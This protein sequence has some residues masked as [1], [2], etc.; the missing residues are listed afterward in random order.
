MFVPCTDE[1]VFGCQLEHVCPSEPP[2]VPVFVQQCIRCIER[3]E[4]NMKTDGLYRA[5]GN[6]SQVQKIRLQVTVKTIIYI[7]NTNV[8]YITILIYNTLSRLLLTQLL[9][10]FVTNLNG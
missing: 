10:Y 6:L 1:P 9:P 3:S 7:T 2:R 5:S 4:E 8:I